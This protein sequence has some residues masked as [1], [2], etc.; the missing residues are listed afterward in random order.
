MEAQ[1]SVHK[2]IYDISVHIQYT[3]HNRQPPDSPN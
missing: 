1:S 2:L 3:A